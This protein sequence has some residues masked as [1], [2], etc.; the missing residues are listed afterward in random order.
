MFS[1]G[2]FVIHRWDAPRASEIMEVVDV[3]EDEVCVRFLDGSL[4]AGEVSAWMPAI[5]FDAAPADLYPAVFV[6]AV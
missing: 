5:I 4:I 6:G 2:D 1:A 3:R